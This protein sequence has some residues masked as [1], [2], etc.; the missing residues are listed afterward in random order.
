MEAK[1]RK[2]REERE[3]MLQR[4][5]R[6]KEEKKRVIWIISSEGMQVVYLWKLKDNKS[7]SG[8]TYGASLM[9]DSPSGF[10]CC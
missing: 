1:E 8:S 6:E 7:P 2:M 10:L 3:V 5:R 9:G 4:L